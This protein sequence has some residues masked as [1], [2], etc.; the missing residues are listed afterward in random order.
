MCFVFAPVSEPHGQGSNLCNGLVCQL[1][2]FVADGFMGNKVFVCNWI[3]FMD[4]MLGVCSLLQFFMNLSE[5]K[6]RLYC[7]EQAFSIVLPLLHHIL[8][9]PIKPTFYPFFGFA[10]LSLNRYI[11]CKLSSLLV[12]KEASGP[13]KSRQLKGRQPFSQVSVTLSV[14]WWWPLLFVPSCLPQVLGW[15]V[16]LLISSQKVIIYSGQ[17]SWPKTH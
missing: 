5:S 3:G 11:A 15:N 12:I 4:K 6:K 8:L 16:I 14:S 17:Y 2:V 9:E 7:S 13:G 1:I 10:S